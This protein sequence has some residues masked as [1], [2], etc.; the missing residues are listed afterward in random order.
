MLGF[1][2]ES[3]HHNHKRIEYGC[4]DGI[5]QFRAEENPEVR[6]SAMKNN[7]L[8]GVLFSDFMILLFSKERQRWKYG[9]GGIDWHLYWHR[10]IA[11]LFVSIFN[12]FLSICEIIYIKIFLCKEMEILASQKDNYGDPIFILGQPRSGTTL[13]HSL[14][15]LDTNRFFY[16]NTFCAGFPFAFLVFETLGKR[17][18]SGILS[19]TRPMDNMPLHFELPQEEELATALI[20][21]LR[22]S[23]YASL[24]FMKDEL[25]YRKYQTM[26]TTSSDTV[27][28]HDPAF[29]QDNYVNEEDMALWVRCFRYLIMKLKCRELLIHK[30]QCRRLVLKSPCHTGRVQLLLK[31]F[32]N[33]KFIYIHRNPY[34]VFLSGAY[35]ASTTYGYMFLQRPTDA[36]LQEYILRQGEILVTEY[37]RCKDEGI[38][39]PN[40]HV[41]VS[42]DDLTTDT[43]GTIQS[44]YEQLGLTQKWHDE[45]YSVRLKE[46]C[47]V[48][49]NYKRNN[50]C[51][52]RPDDR[53]IHEIQTRWRNQFDRFGYP[54]AYK[55]SQ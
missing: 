7:P 15:A 31:L 42:F 3:T 29:L 19:R 33:A 21:G 44:I 23:P 11:I 32:P 40:N 35:M 37:L 53:L 18:F 38:L 41:E 1:D 30:N 17:L 52:C 47:Y 43:F 45:P 28:T 48:L 8:C 54:F 24:Y 10:I 6:F 16:C 34:Q 12:S 22:V 2:Q 39:N 14:L 4:Q 5:Y 51:N 36:M 25:V 9:S 46:E 20:T 55:K 49:K 27:A 50:F 13:L 26:K